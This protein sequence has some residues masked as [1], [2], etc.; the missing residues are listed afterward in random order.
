M[1]LET[2]AVL[3]LVVLLAFYAGWYF[4]DTLEPES[5]PTPAADIEPPPQAPPK[6]SERLP[7]PPR[8]PVS[9]P[10]KPP[11]TD[12]KQPAVL[13]FPRKLAEV[14]GYLQRR[15]QDLVRDKS[16]LRLLRLEH[17]IGRLVVFIDQLPEKNLPRQ[18]LPVNPPAPPFLV[19][20]LDG[21]DVISSANARRYDPYIRLLTAI[22][23]Q[24]LLRIYRG[25]YPLF[26]QAWRQTGQPGY[27]NDRLI[28]VID[29]LLA[30][31][32]PKEPIPL[33]RHIN[34]YRFADP[35]LEAE[36]AGRKL[37]LRAGEQHAR[38]LLQWLKELRTELAGPG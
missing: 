35:R 33:V 4:Y 17:F 22:P 2:F 1:K 21:H 30:T 12:A 5:P 19:D 25:L 26:Q 32:L 10:E 3:L 9:L 16:L 27:F 15:L 6:Q 37:L 34:R 28:E 11:E 36:S 8:H 24:T 20:R 7:M 38:T 31:P 14:D 18:H 13:P 29:H 23:Q